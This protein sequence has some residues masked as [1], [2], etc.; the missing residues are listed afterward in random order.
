M[1]HSVSRPASPHPTGLLRLGQGP[2][3]LKKGRHS[4][5]RALH[6]LLKGR[7]SYQPHQVGVRHRPVEH[8]PRETREVVRGERL[9]RMDAQS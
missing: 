5:G 9:F 8:L 1:K 4:L 3:L 2:N 6:L 7:P